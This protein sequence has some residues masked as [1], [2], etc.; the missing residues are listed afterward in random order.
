VVEHDRE[1]DPEAVERVKARPLVAI[2]H[3]D[4]LADPEEA[5]RRALLLDPGALQQ[6][7]ERARAAVQ[8]RNLGTGEVDIQ[9]VDPEARQRRHQVLDRRNLRA[10]ALE[11]AAQPRVG[12]RAR[13]GADV[14]RLCQVDAAEHDA[15]VGR[16]GTQREI[17]LLAGV[18]AYAC[19]ADQVLEGALFDHGIGLD[20]VSL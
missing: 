15:G 8:D 13:I 5:L 19:R 6:V 14:D 12:D 11:R 4:R 2:A 9:I 1:R 3:L 10:A 20:T 17:D 18:Q 7:D 16:R